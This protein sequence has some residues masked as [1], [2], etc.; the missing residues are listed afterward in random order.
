MIPIDRYKDMQTSMAKIRSD[1]IPT[2]QLFHTFFLP[3]WKDLDMFS[4]DV[5]CVSRRTVFIMKQVVPH[6]QHFPTVYIL[7]WDLCLTITSSTLQVYSNR[8]ME[9]QMSKIREVLSDEKHDW[10]HRVVAVRYTSTRTHTHV[11]AQTNTHACAPTHLQY[12][13]TQTHTHTYKCIYH[14]L[15]HLHVYVHTH[16][17]TRTHTDP[18][19]YMHKHTH[20]HVHPHTCIYTNT[21]KLSRTYTKV[22]SH[23]QTCT[24]THTHSAPPPYP[25]WHTSI[26]YC[27]DL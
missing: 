6:I 18:H 10:E 11:Y 19:T 15:M 22:Y 7:E 14:A 20:T 3:S 21:N 25:T 26:C 16:A 23:T 17:C 1:N 12:I 8:E 9:D 27:L 24:H 2:W 13:H 5:N 4:I